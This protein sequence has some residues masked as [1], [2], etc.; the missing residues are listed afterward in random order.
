MALAGALYVALGI[1]TRLSFHVSRSVTD[2]SRAPVPSESIFDIQ[3]NEMALKPTNTTNLINQTR[4]RLL[5]HIGP[6][7][8]ASTTIQLRLLRHAGTKQA[9]A[10][11]GIHVSNQKLKYRQVNNL[12]NRC[13]NHGSLGQCERKWLDAFY[14]DFYSDANYS[15]VIKSCET[16]SKL[17]NNTFTVDVIRKLSENWEVTVL[18]VHRRFSSWLPSR[19]QQYHKHRMLIHDRWRGWDRKQSV[20]DQR[21]LGGYL[22]QVLAADQFRGDAGCKCHRPSESSIG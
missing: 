5:F 16:Y 14:K 11:D 17:P 10:L 8:T 19:Y 22:D 7:K 1:N 20:D 3:Q 21:T 6:T 18:M 15:T 9:M 13:L 2:E 12:R 4:P